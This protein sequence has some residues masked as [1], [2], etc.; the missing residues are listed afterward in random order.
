MLRFILFIIAGASLVF[1]LSAALRYGLRAA[2][3]WD[4]RICG[5][6]KRRFRGF[7][8]H[9]RLPSAIGVIPE[10][11]YFLILGRT[12][13]FC[14]RWW[15]LRA[16]SYISLLFFLAALFSRK[17]VELYYS[18]TFW[19]ENGLQA[20]F[21]SGTAFWYLNIVNAL[22]L[23]VL[24]FIIIESIRMHRAWAPV[25]ILMYTVFSAFMAAV[26]VIMLALIISVT[27][28]YIAYR[29]IKFF[30]TSGRKVRVDTDDNDSP[31]EKLNNSFRRFRAELYAWEKERKT[32]Q[33]EEKKEKKEPVIIRRKPRVVRKPRP[34]PGDDDIPRFYPD[35]P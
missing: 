15:A 31:S 26:T 6:Q 30:F 17:S 16:S 7:R 10:Y 8:L 32:S 22:F 25:R 2:Y 29:I 12:N 20:M 14:T 13:Y 33:P 24:V 1:S 23:L 27:F 28:L 3:A 19:T 4:D 9:F 21:T 18:G 34:V 35:Q 11:F 5:R